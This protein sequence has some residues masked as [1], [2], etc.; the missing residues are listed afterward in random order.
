[1]ATRPTPDR[2]REALFSVLA[3]RLAG[4]TFLDAYAGCGAVGI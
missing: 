3:P 1:M 2:L 4:C